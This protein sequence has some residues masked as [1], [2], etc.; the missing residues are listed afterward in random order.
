M[1]PPAEGERR[2]QRGYGRQ[3]DSAAAAI[4]AA[5]DRTDLLWVGLADR[6]A[7]IVDDL[8]LGFP[9][10]VVGHQFKTS[11]FPEKFALKTLLMGASGL[12]RPLAASWQSLKSA[13]PGDEIEI[14]LVTNDYP[15]TADELGAET[16]THSA[17]FL[18]EFEVHRDRTLAEW[19]NT[20]WQPFVDDIY[21]ASGLDEQSFQEFFRGFRLLHDRDADF[22]QL[23][24][25][26]A[27]EARL[28]R[29]IAAVLP[30]L[31]T[32]PRNKDRW[33]RAELLQELGWRDR[34][35]TRHDHRFPVGSHVQ[36]NVAT[37]E[38][39][40]Q[41]VRN[42]T[43]G[44]V[45]LVGPPG[46]GKSTLLQTSLVTERG[47]LVVRYLAYV[48]G[49]GQGVGRGEA[50]DFLADM[51][52][53][54][55]KSGLHG[56]RF[57]D[58]SLSERR[59]QFGALLKEAGKRYEEDRLRTLIV[60]DGLD[61]VPREEKPENSFLGELPLPASVPDGVLFVLGTQ[62]VDL[63]DLKPGV[64]DQAGASGRTVTVSPLK[65]ES[66]YRMA[67]ALKLDPT[68]SR[69]RLFEISRGH[70]LVTRYLIESLRDA[71]SA[72][73]ANILAGSI[74]FEGDLEAVYESAWRGIKDD[75][76]A[77]TVLAYIARAEGPM[78][79]DLLV[80]AI[81]EAAIDR[82]LKSTKHLLTET[83]LGWS[84]FHNSFRL[85]V[86]GK[87]RL[88]LGKID[89]TYSS[90]VYR[91]LATLARSAPKET[92]QH[93]LELRYLARAGDDADVLNIAY[94][95]RFRHQLAGGRSV[96]EIH[97]DIRLALTAAKHRHDATIAFRLL[98]ARDEVIRRSTALEGATHLTEA[99]VEVGDLN[100]AQAFVEE[101]GDQGYEV[102]DALLSAGEPTRAKD[103]F[104]KLEP[105]QK[106]L[107]GQLKTSSPR[108]NQRDFAE[109]AFRVSHFREI[110]QINEEIDRLSAAGVSEMTQDREQAAVELAAYLRRQVAYAMISS[111]P[112]MDPTQLSRDLKLPIEAI[113][114]LLSHAA[115][116][117][118]TRGEHASTI[119]LLRRAARHDNF[120]LVANGVRR[121]MALIAVH[122]AE[123]DVARDI[124]AG[125]KVPAI[126]M[127][128]DNLDDHAEQTA[129]A[130]I[131]HAQLSTLLGSPLTDAPPSKRAV[132]R[133]L[134]LHANAIG[135]LLGRA[136]AAANNAP[137]G[138]IARA[139]KAILLYLARV[140]PIGGG[141]FFAMRQI[142]AAAPALGRALIEAA[143]LC[144][145]EEFDAVLAE[146]DS[147]F[148]Q[149]EGTR[150]IFFNLRREV[151]VAAY[152]TDGG[153]DEASRRLEPLI[154]LRQESTPSEQLDRLAILAVAFARVGNDMRA[155]ALL[156]QVHDTTLGYALAPKKDPQYATW[157]DLLIRAN[158]TDPCHRYD[159]VSL[160]MR[161][162]VGMQETEG[163]S[164]A[165]RVA[166][167][168][169][170][171]A[172]MCGAA[173][174]LAAARSLSANGMIGWPNLIDALLLG[175]VK[176]RPELTVS[177]SAAWCS[178]ALPYYIEPYYHKSRVGEFVETAVTV[179]G[180]SDLEALTETFRLA[181][182]TESRVHE[183]SDL[184][185]RLHSSA[186][187]RGYASAALDSA[188]SRWKPEAP[189]PRRSSTPMK[190]DSIESLS[191]LDLAFQRETN[192]GGPGYEAPSAFVRLAPAA[193]FEPARCVFE[194]WPVLQKDSRSR[195]LLF[196][197]AVTVGRKDYAKRLL[198]DYNMTSDEW[199]TWTEWSGGGR[200]RY[201]RA[202]LKLQGPAVH[203]RA[204]EDF[205][206]SIV[207][208]REVHVSVMADIE[209]ILTVVAQAPDWP[210]MW[211]SLAEQL[212]TTREYR[213][214]RPFEV[215]ERGTT[216]EDVIARLFSWALSLPLRELRRHVYV[217]SQRLAQSTN[218][219]TAFLLLVRALLS[220]DADEPADG[221]H[222]LLLDDSD[223][224]SSE[225]RDTISGLVAHPDYAV[226]E[227]ALVLSSRW[228]RPTT[229]PRQDLPPFYHLLLPDDDDNYETSALTDDDYG[230][231]RVETPFGWT[232]MFPDQVNAL[233]RARVTPAH[234][235]YRCKMLIETWG[236]LAAFGKQATDKVQAELAALEMRMPYRR[237]HVIVAAR[238]LRY[239][240]GEL[241]RAGIL[242]AN[243]APVLLHALSFPA[244]ALPLTAPVPRPHFLLRPTLDD[245]SWRSDEIADKWLQEIERDVAPLRSHDEH[246]IGEIATFEIHKVTQGHFTSR[247][248]R[249]PFLAVGERADFNESVQM[250]PQAVWADGFKVSTK[251]PA[252]SIVR[253]LSERYMPDVPEYQL[254]ICPNWTHQLGWVVHPRNWLLYVDRSGEIVART[255]WW[256]DAGPV[257]VED[258]AIWGEG[259]YISVTSSG[260]AQ[261]EK[262]RGKLRIATHA[263]RAVVRSRDEG[264]QLTR[265]AF[266]QE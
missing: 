177:C 130:V 149:T 63:P 226:A 174:G 160:L 29:E 184:L 82:A 84:V 97:A 265:S 73:R 179:V 189:S 37:E 233:A 264:R 222:L 54:L 220:G 240:A 143:T 165:Y 68:I 31:I 237:P 14:R 182:E 133:P 204:Y 70:P 158:E 173:T 224:L 35:T 111:Q 17:A 105:L 198:A 201:F 1:I 140:M 215:A 42:A 20:R 126:S 141:D 145:K 213:I 78:P 6:T 4:Y 74:G 114:D 113:P 218:G 170:I 77:C 244:P 146:F 234:V 87:P 122:A 221:L 181:I 155:R 79:L 124:F 251:E 239:V 137:R 3:Y 246:I 47:L 172:G 144:G 101:Y 96:S 241:R 93:W 21:R 112:T 135:V 242:P 67:D 261:I 86:L 188:L 200:L 45:S 259:V 129:R 216:D 110:G 106:L 150:D 183:R 32:D 163:R 211:A 27:D 25:L 104:D 59:E 64:R 235:H 227:A 121:M 24:R 99:L 12:L 107:T 100:A 48:P 154:A 57:R 131:D 252:R 44:Y 193:G 49:V 223:S 61:H 225:L 85:F 262:V 147:A 118:H 228:A 166:S 209:E 71:D 217:G 108:E 60:V 53:Q 39:L 238:A 46:V 19:R 214:G 81:P 115:L 207:A 203:A 196:D 260:M 132:L 34:T 72:Q 256:R 255:V 197:L 148:A 9:R 69:H 36:R 199:A 13:T 89:L 257:D 236:G 258:D 116:A 62:T 230:A 119:E 266:R 33:T 186:R 205:V 7:G 253:R 56:L 176:R 120:Q 192:S 232:S 210:A 152:R 195:F 190:Y 194:R 117:A 248:I 90:S 95:E 219:R 202:E 75:Q 171:E 134:Q 98:L 22:A 15:S 180:D 243:E 161:Q 50:V 65:E 23:H 263:T 102:V 40:R 139:A 138:E 142:A 254:V 10:K 245:E 52:A 41:S 80:N 229:I 175:M 153:T 91:E 212:A 83:S 92:P 109:W 55:K 164:A 8:V 51:A 128:D 28:A 127:F 185:A 103:L 2:A 156:D 178:L 16:T 66:V 167:S 157:L 5:L 125:L 136:R 187:K 38:A 206:T 88:R 94:S 26:S 18:A 247:R 159:R 151:A 11:Q 43:S 208:G 58:E 30:R 191:D 162:V 231:M 168:L 249:A 123:V 250:L 169:I 76:E